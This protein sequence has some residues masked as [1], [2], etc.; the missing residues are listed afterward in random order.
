[1]TLVLLALTIAITGTVLWSFVIGTLIPLLTDLVTKD[2]APAWLKTI[3]NL[4]LAAVSGGLSGA[5]SAGTLNVAHWQQ[6]LIGI[7][8]AW[9]AS[10]VSFYGILKP[11]GLSDKLQK[12]T[13]KFGISA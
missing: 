7:A 8:V 9:V 4:L 1:M 12:A 13:G 2:V 3:V 10:I 5:L 11:T 6:V